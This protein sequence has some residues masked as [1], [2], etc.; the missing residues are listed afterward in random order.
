MIHASLSSCLSTL[1]FFFVFI[2]FFLSFIFEKDSSIKSRRIQSPRKSLR[3]ER[4]KYSFLFQ[5][6][7]LL[8]ENWLV[9]CFEKGQPLAPL[10]VIFWKAFRC[11]PFFLLRY[12]LHRWRIFALRPR[13]SRAV[14]ETLHAPLRNPLCPRTT[15]SISSDSAHVPSLCSGNILLCGFSATDKIQGARRYVIVKELKHTLVFGDASMDMFVGKA[16]S[17]SSPSSAP[18]KCAVHCR[19]A[20]RCRCRLATNNHYKPGLSWAFA[21]PVTIMESKEAVAAGST[22]VRRMDISKSRPTDSTGRHYYY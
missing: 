11:C 7:S 19:F 1:L 18:W 10:R 2:A 5:N 12:C 9:S 15:P 22:N 4:A 17:F 20:Y 3:R 14:I 13:S 21:V 16:K 6:V 8:H